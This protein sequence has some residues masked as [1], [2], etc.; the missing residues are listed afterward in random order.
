MT[1]SKPTQSRNWCFTDFELL[2]LNEIYENNKDIIRYMCWGLETC[3]TTGRKHNQGWIQFRNKKRLNG[4]RG[5]FKHSDVPKIKIHLESCRGSPEQNDTYCKKDGHW[6]HIGKFKTQG[7]R[8]DLEQIARELMDPNKTFNEVVLDHPEKSIQYIN[9]MLKVHKVILE[10]R[11]PAWR[12]VSVN[13]FHGSTGTGKTRDAMNN[14]HRDD[15]YKIQG[16]QI[17]KWWDGYMGQKHIVIDEYSN[18]VPIQKL[19][20]LLDGY[21]LRL[22]VKGS[23]VYANWTHVTITT[24]LSPDEFHPMA[25]LEHQKALERRITQWVPY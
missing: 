6:V 19:L 10:E 17:G 9:G 4:V 20:C 12:N 7:C 25:K 3:P 24:N 23:F 15:T 18:D 13:I 16:H 14:L 1:K 2:P 22:E 8:S 21:K 11:T 5:A